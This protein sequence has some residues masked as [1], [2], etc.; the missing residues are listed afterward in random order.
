[1]SSTGVSVHALGPAG[2]S[3]PSFLDYG[4]LRDTCIELVLDGQLVLA[5]F[6]CSPEIKRVRLE[7]MRKATTMAR[8]GLERPIGGMEEQETSSVKVKRALRG[9]RHLRRR[10]SPGATSLSGMFISEHSILWPE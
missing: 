6:Y 10:H 8:L 5:S 4:P 2:C 3:C 7:A 1:M 9:D